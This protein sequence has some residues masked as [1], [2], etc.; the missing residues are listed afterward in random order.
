MSTGR[1]FFLIVKTHLSYG[2]FNDFLVLHI[3]LVANQKLIDTLSSIAINF[4]QPLLDVVERIHVGHIVDNADTVCSSVVR[5]CNCP[6][7]FLAG[8]IPLN[9]QSMSDL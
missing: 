9:S 7:S 1:P 5:R 6:E 4:L 2:V 3:T 8:S